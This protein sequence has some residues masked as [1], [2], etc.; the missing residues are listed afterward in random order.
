MKA[1]YFA[2]ISL[3]LLGIGAAKVL[4]ATD[5]QGLIWDG[6]DQVSSKLNTLSSKFLWL[7][8]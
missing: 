4:K 6:E 2:V 5:A 8:A 7:M 3:S 1:G